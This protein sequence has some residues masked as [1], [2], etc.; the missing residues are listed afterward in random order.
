ME[1]NDNKPKKRK[2][3]K[4]ENKLNEKDNKDKKRKSIKGENQKDESEHK[5]NHTEKR[6]NH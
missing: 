2:S 6:E 1:K 4:L 3:I 5:E